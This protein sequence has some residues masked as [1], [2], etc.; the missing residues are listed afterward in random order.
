MSQNITYISPQ[1][2]LP[3][4]PG[5]NCRSETQNITMLAVYNVIS[6]IISY[7]LATPFFFSQFQRLHETSAD[8]ASWIWRKCYHRHSNSDDDNIQD[9]I[10]RAGVKQ[11][12][13]YTFAEVLA[14]T[15]G[16]IIISLSAPCFAG[17]SLYIN[18]GRRANVWWLIQQWSTRPVRRV[19]WFSLS[20]ARPSDKPTAYAR[21]APGALCFPPSLPSGQISSSHALPSRCCAPSGIERCQQRRKDM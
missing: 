4:Q 9:P 16:T 20:R 6:I 18:L 8:W 11:E 10:R 17:L 14:T 1:W 13:E 12:D 21:N 3:K 7:T 5:M 15:A 19:C 2:L